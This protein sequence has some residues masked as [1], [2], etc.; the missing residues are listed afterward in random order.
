MV[1]FRQIWGEKRGKEIACGGGGG[2]EEQELERITAA[3]LSWNLSTPI[4]KAIEWMS[5]CSSQ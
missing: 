5:S 3:T 4:L 2:R 1:L